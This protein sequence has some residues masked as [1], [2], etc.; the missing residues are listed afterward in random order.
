MS[1][2]VESKEHIDVLV[3]LARQ[4]SIPYGFTWW[5]H[6]L[7][8]EE[9]LSGLND[10][11]RHLTYGDDWDVV[12]QMLTNENVR[13]V[14]YRYDAD[15]WAE[16]PDGSPALPGP[17]EA[18]YL[19]PYRWTNPQVDITPVEGLAAIKG[20]E[21]QSCEHPGWH[22]SE[23]YSFCQSL[24]EVLVSKLPGYDAAPWSWDAEEIAKRSKVYSILDMAKKR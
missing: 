2:Y 21:Y 22:R 18:W 9:T 3:A 12:G 1:A 17:V 20:Y 5:E 11:R 8:G 4:H 13:S 6:P 14:S 23:A 7:T 16:E 10:I 19:V 15:P 24:R